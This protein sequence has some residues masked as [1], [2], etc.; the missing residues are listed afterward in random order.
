MKLARIRK[1][2]EKLAE[3]QYRNLSSEWTQMIQDILTDVKVEYPM[4]Q[5]QLEHQVIKAVVTQGKIHAVKLWKQET[6]QSLMDS[7]RAVEAIMAREGIESAGSR[8]GRTMTPRF[9]NPRLIN[10][11]Q[12]KQMQPKKKGKKKPKTKMR[13]KLRLRDRV[14][15]PPKNKSRKRA[16]QT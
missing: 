7:K 5:N 13:K 11:S 12:P 2:R 4:P 3:D 1:I 8:P 16:N 10:K 9:G 14:A 15:P 6:D